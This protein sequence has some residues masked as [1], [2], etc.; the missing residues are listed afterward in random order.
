MA[1]IERLWAFLEPDL[2][3]RDGPIAQEVD[4]HRNSLA[5]WICSK[6][7][8]ADVGLLTRRRRVKE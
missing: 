3:H 5:A 1:L 4:L 6:K 7:L 8:I 2:L